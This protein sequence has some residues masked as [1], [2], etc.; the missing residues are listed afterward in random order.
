MTMEAWNTR[1]MMWLILLVPGWKTEYLS[2]ESFRQCYYLIDVKGGS[3]NVE[4][5]GHIVCRS[6]GSNLLVVQA[7]P[8]AV[9]R[10]TYIA[11]KN[12]LPSFFS[13]LD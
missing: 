10:G 11:Q 3:R 4:G 1:E 2:E 13:F 7:L 9:H 5:E 12:P 6:V 8:K